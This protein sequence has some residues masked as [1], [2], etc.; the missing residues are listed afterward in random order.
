MKYCLSNAQIWHLLLR[1]LAVLTAELHLHPHTFVFAAVMLKFLSDVS[2][3]QSF[4]MHNSKPYEK[5]KQSF[6]TGT[7][8]TFVYHVPGHAARLRHP[9]NVQLTWML[10]LSMVSLTFN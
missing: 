2:S 9:L 10:K 5:I 8:D 7:E 3:V 4:C 1:D 6:Q